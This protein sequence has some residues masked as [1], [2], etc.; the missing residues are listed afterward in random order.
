MRTHPILFLAIGLTFS[1]CEDSGGPPDDG[2]DPGAEGTL[3]VS[4]SIEG[5]DPDPDGYLLTVDGVDSLFLELTG[6]SRIDLPAGRHTLGLVGVAEQC[7]VSPGTPI[8]VDLASRET[9]W[10]VFQVSC[11]LTGAH[12]TSRTSGLDFDGDGY[13]LEV[14][15]ADRVTLASNDTVRIRLEAGSRT[16][17][18]TGLATN[19]TIEGSDSRTVAIMDAEVAPI[20]FVVTCTATSGVIGVTIDA[21][22]ENTNG[23]YQALVDGRAY[24]IS[25]G[26]TRYLS[27]SPGEHEVSV[28][29]PA[30]CS[31]ETDPQTVT[32]TAGG[33]VRDTVEVGFSI[34]C[35]QQFGRIRVT[36]P[37]TGSI[38]ASHRY[39]V[40][41]CSSVGFTCPYYPISLGALAP[42]DTLIARF[43]IIDVS[44]ELKNIPENCRVQ[45]AN[46][47]GF[48]TIPPNGIRDVR[49]PV[50]CGP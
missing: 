34:T 15:G 9:T 2:G 6:T 32:V 13:H 4:T 17:A 24:A 20:E 1:A 11:P 46:P 26:R 10:V 47:T 5:D 37:T 50:V 16:I 23:E 49:F 29:A 19:C 21:S 44:I 14:D 27:A 31:V 28:V 7:S 45:T 12:V 25:L 38:P 30:N 18:L 39:E 8:D 22:G 43:G 42:G 41:L 36:A 48:F 40:I 35:T 3:V 33:L